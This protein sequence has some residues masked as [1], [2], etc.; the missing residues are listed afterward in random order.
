MPLGSLG[1]HRQLSAT[2]LL[3]G[4]ANSN[5]GSVRSRAGTFLLQTRWPGAAVDRAAGVRAARSPS[6]DAQ[7]SP[8]PAGP[9]TPC[10]QGW[11]DLWRGGWSGQARTS[12]DWPAPARPCPPGGG[13]P[14]TTTSRPLGLCPA[15]H[16]AP[17]SWAAGPVP[18]RRELCLWPFQPLGWKGR[19]PALPPR[20][21]F[22]PLLGAS[23]SC[24]PPQEPS[25]RSDLRPR[26]PR[27]ALRGS[28][29][30]PG[31][32][33]KGEAS[34]PRETSCPFRVHFAP[35]PSTIRRAFL[36]LML[37]GEKAT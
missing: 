15:A 8:R 30:A 18:H 3:A 26:G 31:I 22:T 5:K 37:G 2:A 6:P 10:P 1:K 35:A 34:R 11:G 32:P 7:V 20:P 27:T 9:P 28:H 12:L 25:P 23:S 24:T 17:A 29:C 14:I 21:G 33:S 36:S 19:T 4:G 16:L 13:I